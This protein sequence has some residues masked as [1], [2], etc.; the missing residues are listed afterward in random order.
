[1]RIAPRNL[2]W[3]NTSLRI[4]LLNFTRCALLAA[5]LVCG[6]TGCRTH[7]KEWLKS[8][9][10]KLDQVP[11]IVLHEGDTI[12][13]T[14]PGAPNLN[15]VQ[16]IRRDGMVSLQA[17]GEFKASGFTPE[18]LEKELLRLYDEQ[19]QTKEVTVTIEASAFP[20]YVTGAVQHSGKITTDRPLTP[21]EAIM[22]AGG[23][24]Y[25][26]A[27]M[28]AVRIIRRENGVDHHYIVD[29]RSVMKGGQTEPFTL[30]PADIVYVPEKF[31]WF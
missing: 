24:E 8:A 3:K 7:H 31:T 26:K 22:E 14:F 18:S 5:T 1:M 17:I 30:K 25:T 9:N 27:N 4:P 28:K 15:S 6:F 10:P 29:L 16:T 12:R 2:S 20:F 11:T 19:I 21:L 13:I 23:F